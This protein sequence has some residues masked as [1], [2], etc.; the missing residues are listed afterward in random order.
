MSLLSNAGAYQEMLEREAAM[1]EEILARQAADAANNNS[2]VGALVET[3][4]LVSAAD[5]HFSNAE[6]E[7]LSA[8]VS[9]LTEG[10]FS[11]SEIETMRSA[12]Q[13]RAHEGLE[14]RAKAI[15]E[16][17]TDMDLRRSAL[18]AASAAAWKDGGVGQKEGL[19]LQAFARAF[20]IPINELHKI[21]SEAHG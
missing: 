13:G 17:L 2:Q 19:A 20:G 4:Y 10:R 12:A 14:C 15:A 6:C 21:M 18:L 1:K 11:A 7:E 16:L 9:A 8:H 3:V 5:G